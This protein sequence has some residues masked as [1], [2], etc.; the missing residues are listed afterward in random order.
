MGSGTGLRDHLHQ[1]LHPRDPLLEAWLEDPFV[2]AVWERMAPLNN[3][4]KR[5]L[6]RSQSTFILLLSLGVA[7]MIVSQLGLLGRGYDLY[8]IG[9]GTLSIGSLYLACS[10]LYRPEEKS[11]FSL[12]VP[13]E[14]AYPD[15]ELV[16][17][18]L[19]GVRGSDVAKAVYVEMGP[20][21][22]KTLN[23]FTFWMWPL[24]ITGVMEPLSTFGTF[25]I[26]SYILMLIWLGLFWRLVDCQPGNRFSA[27]FGGKREAPHFLV[28]LLEP[29]A[30]IPII[31]AILVVVSSL[32]LFA[33]F[34]VPVIDPVIKTE[35]IV[36]QPPFILHTSLLVFA[37]VLLAA[38][39]LG[40][41]SSLITDFEDVADEVDV[42][43]E[44][45]MRK[46]LEKQ[47]P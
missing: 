7:Y 33:S 23:H 5:V 45:F 11:E 15:R 39:P 18:W 29:A 10:F 37:S 8:I 41:S 34:I 9:A 31:G 42:R 16:D 38:T 46:I 6:Q 3:P 1:W 24:L 2:E 26:V 30:P 43:F 12:I 22:D 14:M 28:P 36:A 47:L 21:G 32:A 17:V 25:G 35:S 19:C 13:I 27:Y 20:Q 4:W 40:D 44:K